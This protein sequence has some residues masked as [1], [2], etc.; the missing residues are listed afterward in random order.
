MEVSFILACL[1]E[2]MSK[3][4]AG[5]YGMVV[6]SGSFWMMMLERS[7]GLSRLLASRI[8]RPTMCLFSHRRRP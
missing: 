4:A 2:G 1:A 3:A 8:S 6:S 5:R 7:E